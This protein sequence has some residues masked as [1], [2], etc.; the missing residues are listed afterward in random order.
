[1]DR[2]WYNTDISAWFLNIWISELVRICVGLIGFGY[3]G[4]VDLDCDLH[5]LLVETRLVQSLCIINFVVLNVWIVQCKLL[6]TIGCI[7]KVLRKKIGLSQQKCNCCA[8]GC[9]NQ[10]TDLG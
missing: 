9:E 2:H 4:V 1:M 8:N 7:Y 6:V 5:G 10:S 3:L